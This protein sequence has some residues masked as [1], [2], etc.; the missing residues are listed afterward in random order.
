MCTDRKPKVSKPT[1]PGVLVSVQ[2]VENGHLGAFSTTTTAARGSTGGARVATGANVVKPASLSIQMCAGLENVSGI[3]FMF[4]GSLMLQTQALALAASNTLTQGAS[5]EA[6][7]DLLSQLQSAFVTAFEGGPSSIVTVVSPSSD[8]SNPP[9][10]ASRATPV[11]NCWHCK[12]VAS[13]N[14]P[15]APL[16]AMPT[17][18]TQLGSASGAYYICGRRGSV[19]AL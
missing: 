15:N 19:L 18:N 5:S 2:F 4:L 9:R 14:E 6:S 13:N 1:H 10:R 3:G 17:L 16:L 11:T 7:M 12:R 8:L